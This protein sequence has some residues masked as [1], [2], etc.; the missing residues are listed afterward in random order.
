MVT[1]RKACKGNEIF[2]D[3]PILKRKDK[4]VCVY[5]KTEV[6]QDTVEEPS[7][8]AGIYDV[9]TK[10]NWNEDGQSEDSGQ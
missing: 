9:G 3:K 6:P 8:G 5:I 10:P 7:W 2:R 4:S 1:I